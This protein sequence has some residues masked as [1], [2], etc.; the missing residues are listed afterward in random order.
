MLSAIVPNLDEV[1]KPAECVYTAVPSV[2]DAI[3]QAVY[4]APA[5]KLAGALLRNALR[6]CFAMTSTGEPNWTPHARQTLKALAAGGIDVDL[7]GMPKFREQPLSAELLQV[8]EGVKPLPV[9]KLDA[10]EGDSLIQ[11]E[12]DAIDDAMQATTA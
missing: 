8:L 1:I 4:A 3:R 9:D 5:E 6:D 7:S 2:C 10:P 11:E 12:E